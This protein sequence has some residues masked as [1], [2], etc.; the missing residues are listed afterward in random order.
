[1]GKFV[2]ICRWL[3]ELIL[4]V[5]VAEQTSVD[6]WCKSYRGEAL[7]EFFHHCLV[8]IFHLCWAEDI[9]DGVARKVFV[10]DRAPQIHNFLL[11][12]IDT[13]LSAEIH[14]LWNEIHPPCLTASPEIILK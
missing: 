2:Y 9:C 6:Q 12:N 7:K 5:R 11:S 3:S 10:L 4:L 13:E 8:I 1:M 14:K